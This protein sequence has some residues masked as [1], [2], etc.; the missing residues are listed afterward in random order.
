MSAVWRTTSYWYGRWP[1]YLLAIGV[2]SLAAAL[3]TVLTPALGGRG[4]FLLF[5]PAIVAAA[6]LGGI[7]PGLLAVTATIFIAPFYAGEGAIAQ[8][9]IFAVT[10]ASI[11]LLAAQLSAWRTRAEANQSAASASSNRAAQVSREL[12]LLID[13]A[14]NYAI[15]ML[16]PTGHVTIWNIGGERIKGWNESEVIGRHCSMFYSP[17][18]VAAGKPDADLARALAYGRIE[19]ES[20]RLRKD[21]SLFRANITITA[22]HDHDGRHIGFGKVIRDVTEERAAEAAIEANE[23]Q[24]RAILAT[25]PDAM[26]VIDDKAK[27]RSFSAA[28]QQLFGY[29]EAE[30]AGRN[31]RMLMP[32]PYRTEHDGY[33]AHY[34][35][36]GERRVIGTRRR[37]LGERKDG[38]IFPLELS[39][40][41]AL[42]GGQR[43][44]TGF[45][46]DISV[47]E[48][49]EA[50]LHELQDKLVHVSRLSAMGTMA[51]TL[52]H[53]LNQ[54][55]AAVANYVEASRDLIDA[56]EEADRDMLREALNEAANEAFRAGNIVRR[57]REFVARGELEKSVA[58]LPPLIA[59]AAALGLAGAAERGILHDIDL[60]DGL[61]SVLI[62][63]VQIQQVLINL[64]RN[65]AEAMA[66]R[67][68]GNI[69]VLARRDGAFIQLSIVDDG[70]GLAPEIADR[71]FNAFQT[72][73]RDGMGLGLSICRTIVEAHGGRIWAQ[74]RVGGGTE[75]HFT[76][77]RAEMGD[78][79]ER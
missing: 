54:P 31:I 11:V 21:G 69:W 34:L 18:D 68:G 19:E 67:G 29:T 6:G 50:R 48:E 72:T 14:S 71:L 32:D 61:G 62:D 79:D 58:P 33:I 43:M 25:V 57:L 64:M 76:L 60:A 13:G 23:M 63:R 12:A 24:L 53:E 44:F 51:S 20:W 35:T 75:F 7:G 22:L 65:A 37:V 52:A 16:D 49:T 28:A 56:G 1:G 74:A 73:K 8:I 59:E 3:R 78:S 4:V 27:I 26:I 15:Y 55:L 2:V 47:R 30:V 42:G 40:G 17:D 41:E 9:L 77:P 5:F 66:S 45:I 10:G 36:T 46:R 38:S 39:V 70:P